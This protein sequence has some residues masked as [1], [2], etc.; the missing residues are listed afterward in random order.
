[1]VFYLSTNRYIIEKFLSS[2]SISN[3]RTEKEPASATI[4]EEQHSDIGQ[5][6]ISTVEE[7]GVVGELHQGPHQP[8][9]AEGDGLVGE[10]HHGPHQT[11][12]APDG[13]VKT[14][15]ALLTRYV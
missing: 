12:S 8:V 7:T 2:K 10:L 4:S 6:D 9:S 1:M 11:V 15:P 5:G 3:F 14:A 13:S